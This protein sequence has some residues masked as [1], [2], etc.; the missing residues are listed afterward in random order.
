LILKK[1]VE[2][3]VEIEQSTLSAIAEYLPS[4]AMQTG[5][6]NTSYSGKIKFEDVPI[7]EFIKQYEKAEKELGMGNNSGMKMVSASEGV[8]VNSSMPKANPTPLKSQQEGKFILDVVKSWHKGVY[9]FFL[10][11]KAPYKGEVWVAKPIEMEKMT[12]EELGM[13]MMPH[14]TFTVPVDQAQDFMDAM[15]NAGIR[16]SKQEENAGALKATQGHLEDMKK[17]AFKLLDM[18]TD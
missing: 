3:G 16:P 12:E 6:I 4:S 2:K 5:S 14:P 10:H 1:N 8:G 11:V 15:W 17:I 13:G 9:E 18:K 7:S